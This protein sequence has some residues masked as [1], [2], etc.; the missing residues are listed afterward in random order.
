MVSKI[1]RLMYEVHN[2][3]DLNNCL[4][5]IKIVMIMIGVIITIFICCQSIISSSEPKAH[6]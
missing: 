2:T 3:T 4:V 5:M 1:S 6:R